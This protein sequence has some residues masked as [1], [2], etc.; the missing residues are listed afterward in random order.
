MRQ[1][2]AARG[3]KADLWDREGVHTHN[4]KVEL[5]PR[6]IRL[7]RNLLDQPLPLRE[8]PEVVSDLR[9]GCVSSPRLAEQAQRRTCGTPVG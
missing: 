7:S 9:T 6:L 5:V 3:S 8:S 2:E 1:A 4:R